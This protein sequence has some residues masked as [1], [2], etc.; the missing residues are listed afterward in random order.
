MNELHLYQI[1]YSKE[2]LE[3]I[4]PGYKVLNNLDNLRP[5]WYEYWPIR[6]FLLNNNLNE[7]DY[8]GFLSPK[9][10]IKTGFSYCQLYNYISTR[11]ENNFDVFLFS[12]QFDMG[13]FFLNVF[14]QA[15]T[16]DHGFIESF[17]AFLENADQKSPVENLIMDSNQVVFSNFFIAKPKFIKKWFN[18]TEKLFHICEDKNHTLN[19]MFTKK[20]S[21][22]GQAERKVFMLERLASYLIYFN[23]SF[24]VHAANPIMMAWSALPTSKF[25]H[26]AIVSDA[27]KISFNKFKNIEYLNEYSNIRNRIFFNETS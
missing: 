7:N 22:P 23:K 12:P 10:K 21:Y 20:T 5:D 24:G 18:L 4:E 8:Y 3:Q 26:E 15:E 9:F 17:N 16:F 25:Y 11:V 2:T 27:L 19:S 14:E 6:N 13:A 1:A